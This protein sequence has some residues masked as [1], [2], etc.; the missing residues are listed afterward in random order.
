MA[1]RSEGGAGLVSS[2]RRNPVKCQHLRD[3]GADQRGAKTRALPRPGKPP[4]LQGGNQGAGPKNW[5]RRKKR[6]SRR[7]PQRRSSDRAVPPASSS[8]SSFLLGLDSSA[9]TA[10]LPLPP[11]PHIT[12][13]YLRLHRHTTQHTSRCRALVA[14]VGSSFPLVSDPSDPSLTH[15][16]TLALPKLTSHLAAP[17][18]CC[19]P[20]L[21][22]RDIA[23]WALG[24]GVLSPPLF[25]LASIKGPGRAPWP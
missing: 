12:A 20:T 22:G 19:V 1:L 5:R 7:S 23:D 2:L 11:G 10:P 3:L 25:P 13:T 24:L 18:T 9:P 17:C 21:S 8:R 15:V 4:R 16:H 14:Q 6:A